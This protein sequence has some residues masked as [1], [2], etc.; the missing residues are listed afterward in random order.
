MYNNYLKVK[1][2]T[3]RL[4][5]FTEVDIPANVPIIEFVGD[6]IPKDVSTTDPQYL[7]IN[8]DKFKGLSGTTDDYINHSCN[9]NCL[10][11]VAGNRAIL[12]SMYLISKGS[13]L[14][15]D[16]STTSN[17]TL[18]T[19]KMECKCD[20]FFCRK[21][22]SGYQYLNE[23]LKKNYEKKG[24]VPAFITNPTLFNKRW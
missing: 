8:V 17:E 22:I 6:I 23:E 15:F 20:S 18:D 4:G 9:P 10:V 21:I 3:S 16:Y 24:M 11:H 5:V 7:Q 19:W 12:Y 1:S 14:T 13:E 2:S